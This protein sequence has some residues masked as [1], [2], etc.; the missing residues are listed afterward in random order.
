MH[1]K[2]KQWQLQP[3]RRE[4]WVEK[5][6]MLQS[7]PEAFQTCVNISELLR[8]SSFAS[9]KNPTQSSKTKEILASL[10]HR[11]SGRSLCMAGSRMT[12]Q[13]STAPALSW[14]LVY[15]QLL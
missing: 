13:E 2:E 6:G 7:R 9:D 8:I 5:V 1:E 15:V 3:V 11:A 10:A 4:V 14:A 12:H